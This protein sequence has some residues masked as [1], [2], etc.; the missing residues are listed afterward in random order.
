MMIQNRTTHCKQYKKGNA[1]VVK[2]LILV[3]VCIIQLWIFSLSY[4]RAKGNVGLNL[5]L[6]QFSDGSSGIK[7]HSWDM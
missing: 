3:R 6:S 4:V 1:T 7:V 2:K 5:R